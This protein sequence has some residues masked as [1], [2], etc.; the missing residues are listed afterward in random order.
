[1]LQQRPSL[2]L[3]RFNDS[4]FKE[5]QRRSYQAGKKDKLMEYVIPIIAGTAYIPN[6][7]NQLLTELN[8][9]TG[10]D[11]VTPKPDFYDGTRLQDLDKSVQE[12]LGPFIVPTKHE[13]DPVVPNF[14][15]EVKA[16]SG[17]PGVAM[18]QALQNGAHG[19]RAMHSLQSYSK[20]KPVYD[21]NA[22]TI[23]M[24]YVDGH[25]KMYTTYP[26]QGKDGIS[27]EY[28]MTQVRAFFFVYLFEKQH[29]A[30]I[31]AANKDSC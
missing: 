2:S 20:G 11:T 6:Q 28:H 31:S 16:L 29:N 24:T 10:S 30:F 1:M 5:F 15:L 13:S 14:F 4:D 18:L 17:S 27:P 9:M 8:P 25:L 22:Y 12:E 3:L 7:Q 26:T 19:A 21:G 23:T